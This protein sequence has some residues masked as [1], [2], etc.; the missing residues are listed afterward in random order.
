MPCSRAAAQTGA[1]RARLSAIEQLVLRR[2][3]VSEAAVKTAIS[4][5]PAA[6]AASKPFMLGTSTG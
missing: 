2:L 1:R 5:T 3:K 6:S 4:R